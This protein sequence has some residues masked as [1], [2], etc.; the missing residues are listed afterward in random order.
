M[1]QTN[2][3]R[4]EPSFAGG[5]VVPYAEDALQ[6]TLAVMVARV[7]WPKGSHEGAEDLIVDTVEVIFA[8]LLGF[9]QPRQLHEPQMPAYCRLTLPHTF[10]YVR[11][12][13][14]TVPAQQ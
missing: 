2:D 8:P 5:C 9:E 10:A 13:H 12:V 6:E 3:T 4:T 1:R 11:H 7:Q 14:C